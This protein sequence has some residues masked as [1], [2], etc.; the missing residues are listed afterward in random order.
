MYELL[1][2]NLSLNKGEIPLFEMIFGCIVLLI[3]NILGSY[4]PIRKLKY[5][6]TTNLIRN[7]E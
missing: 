1:I 2:Y 3:I 6:N 4:I 7:N 5:I